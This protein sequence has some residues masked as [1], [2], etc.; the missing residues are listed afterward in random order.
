MQRQ[1]REATTRIYRV[2]V[3][4]LRR[5]GDSASSLALLEIRVVRRN[6]NGERGIYIWK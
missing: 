3:V 4:N 1:G 2:A 6:S 5:A